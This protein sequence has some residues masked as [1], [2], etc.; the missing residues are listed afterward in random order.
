MQTYYKKIGL[1]IKLIFVIKKIADAKD[2][3][4]GLRR[5]YSMGNGLIHAPTDNP[6]TLAEYF[7]NNPPYFHLPFHSCCRTHRVKNQ[8]PE[9]DSSTPDKF[10]HSRFESG[11]HRG[12]R[13][14]N[15]LWMCVPGYQ[16]SVYEYKAMASMD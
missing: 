4:L 5:L 6:H 2:R 1:G 3:P 13:P 12:Y 11:H 7:Q 14:Q 15:I 8:N 16:G 10:Y 9:A